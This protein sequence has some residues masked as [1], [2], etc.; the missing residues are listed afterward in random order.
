MV[1]DDEGGDDKEGGCGRGGDG[2]ECGREE[3]GEN[4]GDE[5]K[6]RIVAYWE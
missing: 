5:V 3:G 2:G 1:S 6:I 4:G